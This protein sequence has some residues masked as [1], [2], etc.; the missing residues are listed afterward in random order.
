LIRSNRR[1]LSRAS[2]SETGPP[3]PIPGSSFDK[4]F[5]ADIFSWLSAHK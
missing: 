1:F 2:Q 4:L 3:F 5:E